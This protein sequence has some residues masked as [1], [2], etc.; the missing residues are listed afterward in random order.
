MSE[1]KFK[2]EVKSLILEKSKE[3]EAAGAAAAQEILPIVFGKAKAFLR[4]LGEVEVKISWT[5]DDAHVKVGDEVFGLKDRKFLQENIPNREVRIFRK[6]FERT[7]F[8][9]FGLEYADYSSFT[10]KL[11]DIMKD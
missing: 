8:G 9:A 1:N 2:E 3:A 6:A 10:I 5:Q 7:I 4:Y 11:E